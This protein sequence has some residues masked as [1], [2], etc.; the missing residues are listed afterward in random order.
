MMTDDEEDVGDVAVGESLLC[1]APPR[2]K[3]SDSVDRLIRDAI[4]LY[5]QEEEDRNL[6]SLKQDNSKRII[7][8][9]V[10]RI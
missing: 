10:A 7:V 4:V 3:S 6:I 2:W 5:L 1:S 9:N 8:Q